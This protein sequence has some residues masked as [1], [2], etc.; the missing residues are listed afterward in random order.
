MPT[1]HCAACSVREQAVCAA[2]SEAERSELA[3]IGTHRTLHRGEA[4]VDAGDDNYACATLISG[5]L[6]IAA[7]DADGTERIVAL[8]HPAGFVGELFAP[9][10][11]HHVTALTDS[12]LCLFPR[13]DYE[14]AVERYPRLATALL[15]RSTADLAETRAL[16]DLIG[17]RTSLARVAGLILIFG[18]GASNTPCGVAA[19]FDLPLTRGEMAALLGLTI[20]TVSRQIGI[21]ERRGIIKRTG[22]RGMEVL[23]VPSLEEMVD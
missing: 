9:R 14:R 19:R 15:R 17:R 8:V 13:M 1:D 22:T 23:D 7:I 20:E 5:A 10:A 21:L 3:R 6:K 11:H 4:L 2:L 18:R 16:I 12:L